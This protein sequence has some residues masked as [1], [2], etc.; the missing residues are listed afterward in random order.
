MQS[1]RPILKALAGLIVLVSCGVYL[2]IR[3]EDKSFMDALWLA[4]TSITTVGFGDV[5]PSTT[6]GRIVTMLLMVGGIGLLTYLLST[7][8]V[9]ALE[10]HLSDIW[11]KR[12]MM[13]EIARLKNHMIVCGAG[14]VGREVIYELLQEN[15]KFVVI[16][17]DPARLEELRNEGGVLFIAGD[18]TED[19]VLLSAG[20]PRARGVITTLAEDAGN[21]LITIACK[22]FNPV[23]RVVARANR[24]ESIVRLRR[25]GADTV[26]CPAAIAGNRMALASLKP[27]SVAFVQTLIEDREINLEL[28]ELCL[29]D[30]SPFTNKELK[31]SRIR[32]EYGVM[33]LAIKRGEEN[34][35]NPGPA[36]KLLPGD[37]LILC[38][39]SEQLS[40]LEKIAAC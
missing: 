31:D 24:Q 37:L 11:G 4:L 12:R 28:E 27:A 3:L 18:A 6:E 20:L 17:K 9:G 22:D 16:E 39:Q 35:V 38:G 19:K 30:K 5:V 13:K 2:I 10:G 8:F 36:E 32:E 15:Q 7:V 23:A 40:L 1:L 34:I 33:V 21:L 29:S 14:R 26:V 25:A